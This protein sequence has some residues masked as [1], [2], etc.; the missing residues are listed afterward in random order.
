[1][2][3]NALKTTEKNPFLFKFEIECYYRSINGVVDG[4][5]NVYHRLV[6]KEGK[7]GVYQGNILPIMRNVSGSGHLLFYYVV[8]HL[9]Y[10]SEKV[11]MDSAKVCLE[12]GISDS[13]FRRGLAQLVSLSILV[14]SVRKNV[15][16][17]NPMI[18][19]RGDRIEHFKGNIV[20]K[21]KTIKI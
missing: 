20:V 21:E 5:R 4:G 11:E 13:A 15:Y 19:F 6:E 16:W 9:R 17:V 12:C 3:K 1:M 14:R 10:N 8:A 18:L 7:V 2:T